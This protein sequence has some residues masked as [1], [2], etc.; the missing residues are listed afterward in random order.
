MTALAD[1]PQRLDGVIFA[2]RLQQLMREKG[3][4]AYRLA[5]QIGMTRAAVSYLLTGDRDPAWSTVRKLARALGVSVESFDVGEPEGMPS[6]RE[7]APGKP[8]PKPKKG[9]K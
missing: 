5:K 7:A 6:A 2:R 8:G 9:G 4:T 1:K 3:V